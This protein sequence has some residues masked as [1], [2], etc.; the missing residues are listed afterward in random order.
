MRR[1]LLLV[2]VGCG[3]VSP[4]ETAPVAAP[5]SGRDL[6]LRSGRAAAPAP[7]IPA[8]CYARTTLAD[9]T[10][11]NPCW[12]CH[13]KPRPPNFADDSELQLSLDMPAPA[14]TSP[15]TNLRAPAPDAIPSADEILA[16]VREDNWHDED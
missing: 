10:P 5:P 1:F 9:G 16:W 2:C 12:T 15:W 3:Q 6:D 14:A 8:Q 13:Q 11:R 7:F 4:L